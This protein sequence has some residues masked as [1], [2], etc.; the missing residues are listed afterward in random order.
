MILLLL[1]FL[2]LFLMINFI[3]IMNRIFM[4]PLNEKGELSFKN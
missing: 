3:L 4:L 1:L 2:G